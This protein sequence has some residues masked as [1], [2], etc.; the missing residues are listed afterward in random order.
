M[1]ECEQ[2]W[3]GWMYMLT[4]TPVHCIIPCSLVLRRQLCISLEHI[5]KLDYPDKWTGIVDK[6]HSYLTSDNKTYWLG[7]LLALYQLARKYK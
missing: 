3:C 4:S 6:I 1:S 2:G 7:A 5:I